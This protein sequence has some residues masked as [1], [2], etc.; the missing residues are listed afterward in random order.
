MFCVLV[1]L[2]P[3]LGH[4]NRGCRER[5]ARQLGPLAF[6]DETPHEIG[7]IHEQDSKIRV[8]A[9]IV[10]GSSQVK[11]LFVRG[12]ADIM[13]WIGDVMIQMGTETN[14]P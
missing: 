1:L 13:F 11:V 8:I 3:G 5:P 12:Y 10:A 4:R 7:K 2:R 14:T 9:T 6:K